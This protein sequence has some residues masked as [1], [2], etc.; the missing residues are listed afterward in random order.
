MTH[1]LD[2]ELDALAEQRA[3]DHA[4][5]QQADRK[6]RTE[7]AARRAAGKHLQHAHRSGDHSGCRP[8]WCLVV[9]QPQATPRQGGDDA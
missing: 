4:A 1:Q 5:R 9:R 2:A 7:L 8:G 6:L 3:A